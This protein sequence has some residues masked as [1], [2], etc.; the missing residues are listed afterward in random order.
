M[1]KREPQ[2]LNTL[3]NITDI[4]IKLADKG[5]ALVIMD[6]KDYFAEDLR[7]LNDR[8]CYEKLNRNPTEEHENLVNNTIDD[9]ISENAIDEVTASFLRPKKSRTPKFYMLPKIHKEGMPGQPVVSSVSSPTEK[10]SAF[11]D[12]FL[13]P[14]AQELP[15]YIKDT[16]HLI[17]EVGKIFEDTYM[18][19]IDIKSLYTNIDNDE[20]LRAVEEELEKRSVKATPSF[21]IAMLMKLVLILNNFVFNGLNYLQKKGVAMGSRT[22]TP[23]TKPPGQKPP[24]QNL[25]C[26]KP[27]GQNPPE[28]TYEHKIYFT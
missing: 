23:Q 16:T 9:L 7:Q 18:V 21:A 10:I 24:G 28:K 25:P 5:G 8:N 6:S 2:A 1:T 14:I 20:G 26:Q 12:E 22:I 19:T 4:V 13:K 17:D 3:E 11:A 27:P 15:S